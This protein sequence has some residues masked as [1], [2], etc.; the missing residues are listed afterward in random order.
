MAT[1]TAPAARDE[2]TAETTQVVHT[3]I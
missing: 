1:D 3:I 2:Y